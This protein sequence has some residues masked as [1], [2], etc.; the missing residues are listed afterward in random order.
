[1]RAFYLNPQL[2]LLLLHEV[3]PVLPHGIKPDEPDFIAEV[4]FLRIISPIF[5]HLIISISVS[6]V[7]QVLISFFISCHFSLTRTYFD[8]GVSSI[9]EAG[10]TRISFLLSTKIFTFAVIEL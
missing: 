6:F 1:M 9:Y 4:I 5:S 2:V 7:I 8:F 3:H 10:M